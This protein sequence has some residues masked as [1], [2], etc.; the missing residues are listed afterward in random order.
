MNFNASAPLQ[1]VIN[2]RAG[3]SDSDATQQAIEREL[4]AANR[5]G[6]VHFAGPGEL[7]RVAR[8]AA[9]AAQRDHAAVIA[10]GGD[11]TINTV[12]QVAHTLGCTMGFIAEGT[13]N[14]F[15]REHGA[16]TEITEAL[17]WLFAA[18]PEP[19]QVS[20]IN[21]R[22]F[23]VN[24]SIGLHPEILQDRERWQARFG[25]SRAISVSAGIATLLRAQAPLRLRVAWEGKQRAVR[26]LTLFVSNNRLQLEQLGLGDSAMADHGDATDPPATAV[27]LKPIGT[28]AML[29]LIMR[30][31]LGK[32]GSAESVEH[33]PFQELVI[34]PASALQTRRIKVAFD[35]EVAWMRSPI[36]I[37]VLPTP[38]WL[39]KSPPSDT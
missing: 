11:G 29:G 4:A 36:V 1:F 28:L 19:A 10:V 15:A 23:L 33:F 5:A 7:E 31:A 34:Q 35:G 26:M 14:Y 37:R 22:L 39:L 25:R 2:G 27:I 6:H 32:L 17:R 21:D 3:S 12:A 24:T 13:F 18:R 8:D 16:P 30:G 38:L 20:A 9:R